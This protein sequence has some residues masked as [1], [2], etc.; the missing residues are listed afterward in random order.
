[1]TQAGFPRFEWLEALRGWAIIGVILVHASAT[2]GMTGLLG[3][4]GMCGQRGV[5]LF[6]ILSAFTIF[7]SLD[8]RREHGRRAFFI[9]RIA[10]IAPLFWVAIL[11]HQLS[12]RAGIVAGA[13]A[14]GWQLLLGF[15]FLHALDPLAIN[16][17]AIGGWSIAVE[18][19]FY[20]I[21]PALHAVLRTPASAALALLAAMLCCGGASWWLA[22]TA[23]T[24]P[25]LGEYLTFMW[26]PVQLPV[27]L[28]GVLAYRVWPAMGTVRAPYLAALGL[29]LLLLSLPTRNASLYLSAAGLAVLLLAVARA[30][31]RLLVNRLVRYFGRLSYSLYLMHFFCLPPVALL[32]ARL[33]RSGAFASDTFAAFLLSFGGIVALA[34]PLS[35]LTC[36][37]IERP[38]IRLGERLIARRRVMP[39][40]APVAVMLPR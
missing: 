1:M 12:L 23:T 22:A 30:P 15:T 28:L 7:L 11:A 4:L 19:A 34:V 25:A 40:I 24:N 27:F 17:V 5:Q 38:G 2:A 21:A 35:M 16:S 32:L 9:R 39:P 14:T 37:W 29:L 6:Y 36:R 31:H 3:E 33:I 18:F 10:R 8:M 26:P 13:P 20:A